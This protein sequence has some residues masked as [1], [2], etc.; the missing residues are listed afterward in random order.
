MFHNYEGA[1]ERDCSDLEKRS[2]ILKKVVF[3]F[4]VSFV[5]NCGS[6]TYFCKVSLQI[7]F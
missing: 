4:Y 7:C 6:I 2:K 5:F 1:I 3:L